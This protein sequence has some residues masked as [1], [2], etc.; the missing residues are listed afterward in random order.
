MLLKIL[1]IPF[2]L[3]LYDAALNTEHSFFFRGQDTVFPSVVCAGNI[4]PLLGQD[5]ETAHSSNRSIKIGG[6]I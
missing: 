1:K 6:F 2:V 3:A 5:A 4:Y